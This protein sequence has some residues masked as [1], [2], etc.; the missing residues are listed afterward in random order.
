MVGSAR[1]LLAAQTPGTSSV[2]ARSALPRVRNAT[3]AYF[4]L[5]LIITPLLRL[6]HDKPTLIAISDKHY[7][8]WRSGDGQEDVSI[9]NRTDSRITATVPCPIG[10]SHVVA[11][12]V[13]GNTSR[14]AQPHA[15]LAA[16]TDPRLFMPRHSA[17][18]P[19][20]IPTPRPPMPDPTH[21]H[22][23]LPGTNPTA[24]P[25]V[26]LHG[27]GGTN[28][29]S[30]LSPPTSHRRRPGLACA[31]PLPSTAA[32]RSSIVFRIA[33]STRPTSPPERPPWRHSSKPLAPATT[34]PGRPWPSASPTARSWRR[35]CC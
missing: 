22:V 17:I 7:R 32:M 25:F 31:A 4:S 19:S 5:S 1:G 16:A 28:P 10:S 15:R 2:G 12:R 26:L 23:F 18:N 8:I 35:R 14:P 33:A 34:S 20:P 27:S 9:T 13:N 3:G 24:T 6:R 21:A 30:C 11:G 29:N